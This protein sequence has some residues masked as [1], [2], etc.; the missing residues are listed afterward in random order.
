MKAQ[1]LLGSDVIHGLA[2]VSMERDGCSRGVPAS[3][4]IHSSAHR[5]L[6]ISR[7]MMRR[8]STSV[9]PENLH[10]NDL[11]TERVC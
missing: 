11:E 1:E 4:S 8:M 5:V 3:T 7:R 9:Q 6:G 10:G 2:I